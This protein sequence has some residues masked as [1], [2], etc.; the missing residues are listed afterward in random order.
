MNLLRY[1]EGYKYRLV[2]DYEY[3]LGFAFP[4]IAH[5]IETPFIWLGLDKKIILKAGYTTDGPSGPTIDSKNFMRGAF[6]HDALYQL[7]R[8]GYL[9]K[10]A[11]REAA[12]A[13]LYNACREDGMWWARAIY[14]YWA[15]RVFGNR[16]AI[17]HRAKPMLETTNE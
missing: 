16:Y 8:L 17:D 13:V 15:V 6:L 7:I 10:T 12:D 2:A 1:K 14:V 5:E 4:D 9:E 11:T 3:Q